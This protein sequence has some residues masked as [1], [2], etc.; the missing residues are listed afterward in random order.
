MDEE[1]TKEERESTSADAGEGNKPEESK[2]VARLRKDNERME[3]QLVKK[4]EL[5][6]QQREIEEREKMSGT[7]E[8]GAVAAKPKEETPQEYSRRIS[9][10]ELKDGEG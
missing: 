4:K 1:N 5:L 9:R 2:A 8:A 10:N 6:A 3:K 7:A